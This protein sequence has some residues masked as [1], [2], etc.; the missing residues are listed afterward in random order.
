MM[1]GIKDC[2]YGNEMQH[3]EL[4]K[5]PF[6]WNLQIIAKKLNSSKMQNMESIIKNMWWWGWSKQFK[7]YEKSS[8]Y[9]NIKSVR[10]VHVYLCFICMSDM[11]QYAILDQM[12]KLW[13][14]NTKRNSV[15]SPNIWNIQKLLHRIQNE[16]T[17]LILNEM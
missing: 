11:K 8:N 10:Y 7:V 14:T 15:A 6:P 17:P 2:L 1:F 4:K 3:F 9:C 5:K 13:N 16:Y 12:Y